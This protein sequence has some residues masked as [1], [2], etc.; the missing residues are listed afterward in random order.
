MDL[1]R[2][3]LPNLQEVEDKV[4]AGEWQLHPFPLGTCITEIRKYDSEKVVTVHL[5]AGERF[6]EW[7][8]GCVQHLRDFAKEHECGAIEALCR[9]GLAKTLKAMGWRT[10]NVEVRLNLTERE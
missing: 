3:R 6:D 4:K 7:K 1:R 10:R 9:P 5:L 8:D 2:L